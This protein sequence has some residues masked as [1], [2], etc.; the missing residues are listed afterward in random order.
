M[1]TPDPE[2]VLATP[3][4][5]K[6]L[7]EQ[8]AEAGKGPSKLTIG[9]AAAALTAVAFAGG[10]WAATAFGSD[11]ANA[12]PGQRGAGGV[13][14]SGAPQAPGGAAPGGRGGA[15]GTVDRIEGDTL[16]LKGANGTEVKVKLGT[17]TTV[18]LTQPGK[19]S[20]LAPGDAVTVTGERAADGSVTARQV[21]E[22]PPR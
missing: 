6:D 1:T 22:Q 4:D 15:V 11:L 19:V 7:G 16:Y 17:D 9:L 14:P 10:L 3:V 13:R 21:T 12:A 20:D 18:H 5:E 8:L 2:Q